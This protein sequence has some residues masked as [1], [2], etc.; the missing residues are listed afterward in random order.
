[1]DR[2]HRSEQDVGCTF[3]EFLGNTS[4]NETYIYWLVSITVEKKEKI[5]KKT[6]S[7]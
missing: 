4:Q 7:F 5:Y 2:I 3:T 6:A 1:M